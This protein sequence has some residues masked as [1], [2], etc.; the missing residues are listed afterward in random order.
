MLTES[1]ADSV[2]LFR[3]TMGALKTTLMVRR[4]DIRHV[5]DLL[6]RAV[7]L[8]NFLAHEYFRQRQRHWTY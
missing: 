2:K 3:Q 6:A 8:R 1:E 4:A 7:R 5:D